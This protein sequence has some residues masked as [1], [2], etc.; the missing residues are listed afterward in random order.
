V[1]EASLP[2][3]TISKRLDGTV[4]PPPLKSFWHTNCLNA[5][6]E[7]LFMKRQTDNKD[8]KSVYYRS[9][10]IFHS[11]DVDG[12]G[13]GWYIAMRGGYS[14]G[15]FPDRDVAQTIIDGLVKRLQARAAADS[16]DESRK[17][18]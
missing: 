15:P 6:Q 18:A 3:S 5:G 1:Q 10:R 8:D 13:T 14:Y 2:G 11:T 17:S 12:R 4:S 7:D 9:D 16:R